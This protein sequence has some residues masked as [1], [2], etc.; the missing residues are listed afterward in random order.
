LKSS[1]GFWS[2]KLSLLYN[3]QT[4]LKPLEERK[5]ILGEEVKNMGEFTRGI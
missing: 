4:G 2:T 5:K 3:K 1:P